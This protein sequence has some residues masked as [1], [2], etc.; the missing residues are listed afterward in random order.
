MSNN[1]Q[2]GA[3]ATLLSGETFELV[4]PP[5]PPG[6]TLCSRCSLAAAAIG[7][8]QDM[9]IWV[10]TGGVTSPAPQTPVRKRPSPSWESKGERERDRE[11]AWAREGGRGRGRKCDLIKLHHE[12]V[13]RLYLSDQMYLSLTRTLVRLCS[14]CVCVC[15]HS[16]I[17]INFSI[18]LERFR[19]D[20]EQQQTWETPPGELIGATEEV[21]FHK[22]SLWH[23][24]IIIMS[25]ERIK[26]KKKIT[27]YEKKQLQ[28]N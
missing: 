16:D 22:G 15:V 2:V 21:P 6:R 3:V 14:D 27:F 11:I 9:A 25:T 18:R 7:R 24:H 28:S 5:P 10:G 8:P 19:F 26:V 23:K 13:A 20:D 17:L 1:K 12:S 4:P